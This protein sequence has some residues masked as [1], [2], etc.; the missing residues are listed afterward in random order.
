MKGSEKQIKWAS[1]IIEKWEKGIGEMVR[2]AKI[3]IEDGSMPQVWFDVCREGAEHGYTALDK[4]AQTWPASRIIDARNHSYSAKV[5]R[6]CH[7]EYAKRI[8]ND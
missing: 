1:E 7:A 4:I 3:R 2:T 5:E 8:K 6:A